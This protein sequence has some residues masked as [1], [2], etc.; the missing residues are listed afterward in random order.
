MSYLRLTFL[1][2][3]SALLD[4]VQITTFRSAKTQ[5]LLAYLAMQSGRA[6]QRDSLVDLLWAEQPPE[7]ARSSFRLSLFRLREVIGNKAATPPFIDATRQTVEWNPNGDYD[8]D[9]DTFLGATNDALNETDLALAT[10]HLQTALDCYQGDFLAGF[11][12]A[13]APEFDDWVSI[14]REGLH[15]RMVT[16][17]AHVAE[18]AEAAQQFAS[19]A[20]LCRRQIALSPWDETA[21]QRLMRA[22]AL[23]GQRIEALAQFDRCTETLERELGVGLDEETVALAEQIRAGEFDKLALSGVEGM[24]GRQDD[25]MRSS[26][27]HL[28]TLSRDPFAILNRLDP[29]PDQTLFGVDKALVTVESAIDAP[30]R[31]WLISIDGIGGLGKTTL[32]NAAVKRMVEKFRTGADDEPLHFL[33]IGWV[34]AKQEEYLPER[35]VQETGKPALDAEMLMDLLLA[36]LSDG[37]Y[38]TGSSHEKR[39]ALTQLLQEKPSLIVVDNLETAVD[40]QAILPL[41]RHLANPSKFLITSRMSLS[42]QG[43]VYC[44]SLSELD[45]VDALAFL[46]HEAESRGMA[47]LAAASDDQLEAIYETVGG[48]PLALKLVLGQIQFLPLDQVL[49]SLRSAT[50][51][52]TGQLYNYIY[53]Q[54]WQ[55]L[56]EESRHLLLSMPVAPNATFA[57]LGNASG[58]EASAHQ[59]ALMQLRALSL[60]EVGGD[61]TEPR[62]RLHRLTETFLMHEVVKWQGAGGQG[63]R[64]Q[65]AGLQSEDWQGADEAQFFIQRVLQMVEQWEADE[66]VQDLEID[67][68]D[69]EYEAILKAISFGLELSQA[70]PVVKK[71]IIALPSYM[72]R[73][74][75]WAAWHAMLE[76]AIGVAQREEDLDGEITLTA[77]VARLC[78]RESKPKDVV[79]HYARVIRLARRSGNQFEEARACSNLGYAY[80]DGGHWWRS[81]MLSCHALG[82]FEE[83]GSEHGRAHTHNHLGL[84]YTRRSK[85]ASAEQHLK[86]ACT[87]WESKSDIHSSLLGYMNLGV[88]YVE[89]EHTESAIEYLQNAYLAAQSTGELSQIPRIWNTMAIA[90][91]D[92][93]DWTKAEEYA[94]QAEK[95]FGE[96]SDHQGLA[97]VW[98]NLG[99]IFSSS[100]NKALALQYF[101]SS[102]ELHRSLNNQIS[103]EGLQEDISRWSSFAER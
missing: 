86:N 64:L 3:F 80:I 95:L 59:S 101:E 57:Q 39:L 73:R 26:S 96:Y 34:S 50:T 91:R 43:D 71:L 28:V 16:A 40:Y 54:A 75:H 51:E 88:L 4:G 38:P 5:A 68:L 83:L 92:S 99:L 66:A 24:S 12:I 33:D 102:L 62:Y 52:R 55:M 19:V 69:Q 97:H 70:W 22:L 93:T 2:S 53:W 6:H 36:Q 31:S 21:H 10:S 72:E 32:A 67:V 103:V 13:D 44:H 1:G 65:V 77:L 14:T 87:L 46:R 48:N 82:L 15:Q 41:L 29:L 85:W 100:G 63:A 9:V 76:R 37:P 11:S 35:G 56:D 78:Q 23:Q 61:L 27:G 45:A 49:E 47:A 17:I 94:K 7:Q 58:L 20:Y 18:R 74:G 98:H 60:V 81:E 8:L 25:K 89:M 30:E 42:A 84:L 90:Y 79:R